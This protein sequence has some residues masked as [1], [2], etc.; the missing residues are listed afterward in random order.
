MTTSISVEDL[1]YDLPDGSIATH[2]VT[3][4]S[5]A[6]LLVVDADGFLHKHVSELP[7]LLP[8]N[9]LLV[10]NETAVLPA[11]FVTRKWRLAERLKD[12]SC[13]NT[14]PFGK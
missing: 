4:R 14:T 12:F 11:R 7:S 6:K 2:P 8:K 13:N 1:E 5:S 10:V 9:A 3:P